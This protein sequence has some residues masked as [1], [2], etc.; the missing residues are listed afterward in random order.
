[1][2]RWVRWPLIPVLAVLWGVMTYVAFA[3]P[4]GG[5]ELGML[6]WLVITVVL[7]LVGG[8]I[9]LMSSGKLPAYIIELEDEE[10][11]GGPAN[12]LP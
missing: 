9:W 3:T 12:K 5:E 6:E 2:P 7:L 11:R 1:M 10:V 8:M 4:G